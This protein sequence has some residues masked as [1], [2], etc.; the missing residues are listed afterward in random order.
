MNDFRARLQSSSL[1]V[2]FVVFTVLYFI[3][4][5]GFALLDHDSRLTLR[6]ALIRLATAAVFGGV[7]TAVSARQRRRSGGIENITKIHRSLTTGIV[8]EDAE[9][10]IWIPVLQRRRRQNR[11]A[12]WLNPLGFGLFT[13][14]GVYLLTQE[15][16]DP[17]VWILPAFF[18]AA[19]ILTVVLVPRTIRRIDA[20][21]AQL[22]SQPSAVSGLAE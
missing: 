18:L 10:A 16:G 15:P 17:V 4:T 21:L 2:L 14:L 8:P 13:L 12:R 11:Q 22:E 19:G 9:P 1:G 5:Y 6:E 20:L 7:M 3:G